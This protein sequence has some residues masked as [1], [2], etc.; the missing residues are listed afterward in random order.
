M[1]WIGRLSLVVLL[2]GAGGCTRFHA[3]NVPAPEPSGWRSIGRARVTTVESR[4]YLLRD[5]QVTTDSVT[6]WHDAEPAGRRIALHRSQVRR[7]EQLRVDRVR[8]G[9][10]ALV[11]AYAVGVYIGLRSMD[12]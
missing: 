11:G 7:F 10:L 12:W 2:A 1:R 8:T 6:G 4:H 3:S 5:V 9:L